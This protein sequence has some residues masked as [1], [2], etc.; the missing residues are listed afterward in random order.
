MILPHSHVS[1]RDVARHYDELDRFYLE[2]WGEHL[3]HGLWVRGDESCDMAVRQ[4]VDLVAVEAEIRPDDHVCDVGAGYGAGSRQLVSDYAAQVTALTISESQFKYA[5]R[6]NPPDNRLTYLCGDWLEN[7]FDSEQFDAVIA[8]ESA[9][10]MRD[11]EQFAQ[12]AARV[13]KPGGRFVVCAWVATETTSPREV[14][15]LLE[16]IC[17]EGRLAHLSTA[18]EYVSL[19]ENAGLS[20]RYFIDLSRHVRR[21]WPIALRRTCTGILRQPAYLRYLLKKGNS[22]RIFVLTMVRMWMAYRTGAIRYCL[23]KAVK[24]PIPAKLA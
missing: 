23:F 1:E 15:Y 18:R 16:P 2:I 17:R 14:R 20:I 19:M 6:A 8:I 13:L 9:S 3:H 24:S 5:R 10:H 11:P 21:T 12:E 4:L 22:N 7:P